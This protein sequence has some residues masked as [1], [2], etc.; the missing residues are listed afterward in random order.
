MTPRTDKTIKLWKIYERRVMAAENW[1]VAKGAHG[2][3]V[4]ASELHV[5]TLKLS[6]VSVC[7]T[8]RRVFSNAHAYHIN[9]ISMNSDGE[10][11]LSADDLR[12]NVWSLHNSRL[13]F[14]VVDI[15]PANM[16][17]LTEV[18][19]ATCFHPSHCHL[20]MYSTSRGSIKVGDM[21]AAAL[22][23]RHAKQFEDWSAS[24]ATKSYFSEITASVSDVRFVAGDK[25]VSRDYLTVKLWDMRQERTP[26]RSFAVHEHLRPRL[27][28]LYEN[29]SIFDKFEVCASADGRQVL[30]GTYGNTVKVLDVVHGEETT[31]QLARTRPPAPRVTRAVATSDE[32][33]MDAAASAFRDADVDYPHKILHYSWHPKLDTVAIAG[34]NNLHTYNARRA[35]SSAL[36]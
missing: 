17:D 19:T 11:F 12:V 2:G 16:E 18:I 28:D 13:S 26:L 14:N 7:A 6:D 21:R 24:A 8:P 23:D 5:P 25:L 30:T 32:Y 33:A 9:S 31:I 20:L 15:K 10:T 4:V 29:D 36:A 35:P 22:C 34:L 1:N 3:R 27:C